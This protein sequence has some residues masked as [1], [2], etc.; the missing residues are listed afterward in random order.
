M[1]SLETHRKGAMVEVRQQIPHIPSVEGGLS[2][3]E[4]RS[5]AKIF[6]G[7]TCMMRFMR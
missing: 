6:E 5:V 1:M 4:C 3:N 2:G 7:L